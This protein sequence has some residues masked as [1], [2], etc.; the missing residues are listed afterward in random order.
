MLEELVDDIQVLDMF[1]RSYANSPEL[2]DVRCQFQIHHLF[3]NKLTVSQTLVALY[4]NILAFCRYARRVF[5]IQGQD[6]G[7]FLFYC[8]I[9]G[10]SCD[11]GPSSFIVLAKVQWA[12]FEEEFGEIRSNLNRYTAKLGRLTATI[13]M[14]TTLDINEELKKT[15]STHARTFIQECIVDTI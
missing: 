7:T 6:R 13:T 4:T 3:H 12:P 9:E 15:S 5:R 14:N 2:H 8:E 10:L 11:T 1:T